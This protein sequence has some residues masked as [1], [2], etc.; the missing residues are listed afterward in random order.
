MD[1]SVHK[2]MA[3]YLE[4]AAHVEVVFPWRRLRLQH[5]LCGK[6]VWTYCRICTVYSRS[7]PKA[8]ITCNTRFQSLLASLASMMLIKSI[9]SSSLDHAFLA[10]PTASGA[11]W[12]NSFSLRLSRDVSYFGIESCFC[13][14]I[15]YGQSG[16]GDRGCFE[17]VWC[18]ET[19]V[20]NRVVQGVR[21][22]M[23]VVRLLTTMVD[24]QPAVIGRLSKS[25]LLCSTSVR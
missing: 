19:I 16:R 1:Y 21:R 4:S 12:P 20:G 23:A 9:T 10:I 11:C 5:R 25:E 3:A 2:L 13:V 14:A 8:P 18:I 22:P 17:L 15:R 6:R 7:P 24:Y